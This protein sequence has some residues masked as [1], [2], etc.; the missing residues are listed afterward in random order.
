[1]HR[2]Y[3]YMI[4]GYFIKAPVLHILPGKAMF[5]P[6]IHQ[7]IVLERAEEGTNRRSL[8]FGVDWHPLRDFWVE[9]CGLHFLCIS[10]TQQTH[11]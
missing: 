10:I 7:K 3:K 6:S 1:M 11:I 4:F 9:I 5:V 8:T 2:K